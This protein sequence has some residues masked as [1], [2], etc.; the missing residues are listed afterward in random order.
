MDDTLLNKKI[1]KEKMIGHNTIVLWSGIYC[2]KKR[3][4]KEVSYMCFLQRAII[5]YPKDYITFMV[6]GYVI[7]FFC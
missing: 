2:V 4:K 1:N 7:E 3:K 6:P 5:E